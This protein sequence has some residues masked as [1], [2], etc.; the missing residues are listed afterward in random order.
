MFDSDNKLII[1]NFGIPTNWMFTGRI[2]YVKYPKHTNVEFEIIYQV[3]FNSPS[4]WECIKQY[5]ESG[6]FRRLWWPKKFKKEWL[7]S[8]SLIFVEKPVET[9][10]N[11]K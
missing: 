9:I 4:I 7:G 11:C 2:K 10:Y 8:N 6:L 3:D 5:R 1:H